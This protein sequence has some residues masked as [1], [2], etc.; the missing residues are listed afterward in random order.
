MPDNIK[1]KMI[2]K[3]KCG[4]IYSKKF[5]YFLESPQCKTCGFKQIAQKQKGKKNHNWNKNRNYI[6]KYQKYNK[7]M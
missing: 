5:Y 3:C 4:N 6:K 2:F 7:R 1:E